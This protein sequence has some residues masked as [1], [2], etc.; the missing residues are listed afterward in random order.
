MA[1]RSPTG[2]PSDS[3][4]DDERSSPGIPDWLDL[5][6]VLTTLNREEF[7]ELTDLAR[8]VFDVDHAAITLLDGDD[9]WFNACSTLDD[10]WTDRA[11]SICQYTVD[12]DR[13][14]VIPDLDGDP[15]TRDRR[16]PERCGIR[17]YAGAPLDYFEDGFRG[18][19]CLMD[20]ASR[21][22]EGADRERLL[23]FRDHCVRILDQQFQH[24]RAEEAVSLLDGTLDATADGILIVV[25]GRMVNYNE[26]FVDMWDLPE[27]IQENGDFEQ[28]LE[29]AAQ[30]VKDPEAFLH[31]VRS[32]PENG[33]SESLTEITLRDGRVLEQYAMPR[34]VN[35]E[36]RGWVVSFRDV[37]EKRRQHQQLEARAKHDQ[38]TGL[39]KR[40]EFERRS[41]NQ[42]DEALTA[43][44]G[45]AMVAINVRHFDRIN[46]SLGYSSGDRALRKIARRL[47]TVLPDEG[48]LCRFE[49]DK[50]MLT[51]PNVGGES[52]IRNL[53][54]TIH[55]AFTS[56]LELD[57]TEFQLNLDVGVALSPRHTKNLDELIEMTL[58]ALKKASEDSENR[59]FYSYLDSMK[60]YDVDLLDLEK[61]FLRAF[62]SREFNL[63]YQPK[64]AL[65]DAEPRGMEALIR[66]DHPKH[67][68]LS[69][70]VI[71][72]LAGFTSRTYE[73]DCYVL[74]EAAR[75]TGD[76]PSSLRCSVNVAAPTFLRGDEFLEVI[77]ELIREDRL[78]PESLEL[79]ITERTA[80]ES[81]ELATSVLEELR[82]R[83]IRIAV[84]DF[85]TGYSSLVYLS[86]FPIDTLKIDRHFISGLHENPRN[87][88]LVRSIVE[89]AHKLELNVVA[90]GVEVAEEAETLAELNCDEAQGFY[91]AKPLPPE[92]FHEYLST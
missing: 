83:N 36:R 15:R 52:R 8:N 90:E 72:E 22:F 92:R 16:Y 60:D 59:L 81:E 18:T 75:F 48:L 68:S 39:L 87:H 74:R 57:G 51:V 82:S 31:D 12:E 14:L 19:F 50:F 2:D 3:F 28:A 44:R 45:F 4:P 34:T 65:T 53:T 40:R 86:Q 66:W 73:L 43:G 70:H 85:G 58:T 30:Q 17:F 11:D 21:P 37:T 80:L 76:L 33:D 55:D 5:G 24:L 20:S 89:M 67:G 26:R 25:D 46:R 64:V 79:E 63:H 84:D 10:R 29:H 88:E 91:F 13:L 38:L 71:L 27:S 35:S 61:D 47:R 42:L 78:D 77:D 6:R 23:G 1:I 56:E 69:P 32:M 62:G 54:R 7:V 49:S 9:Q 41:S